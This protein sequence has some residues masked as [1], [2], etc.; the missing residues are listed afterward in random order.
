MPQWLLLLWA[1]LLSAGSAH[2]FLSQGDYERLTEYRSDYDYFP[3]KHWAKAGRPELLGWSSKK[4]AAAKSY[5]DTLATAAVVIVDNGVIVDAW[6]QPAARYKCHSVRKSLL[7]ALY[8]IRV[9]TGDISLSSS[10]AELK[11]DDAN[12]PLTDAEK[13]ARVGDLLKAR[14]GVYH[15]AAYETSGMRS[16]R[17]ERGSHAPG[18]HFFY[19][20][21]DFNA[22]LTI[23]ERQT[24]TGMFEEFNSRIAQPLQME[25]FR[26]SDTTYYFERA[27]SQ[28]PA[29]LFRMSALDLARFGLLYLRNG[30]WQ[31]KPIVPASWIKAS[32]TDYSSRGPRGLGDYLSGYGYLWWVGKDGYAA[33]G[34]GEQLLMVMPK[35]RL[36]IVHRVDT[37]QRGAQVSGAQLA[38]LLELILSA[39]PSR[40]GAR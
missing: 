33:V 36:V 32:A 29:Y 37:D 12:P 2:A 15:P 16:K 27:K 26:L 22:L 24:K 3:K 11:I 25:Q 6:G 28:H 1:L 39:R 20:N 30:V 10:L 14:S 19:N 38:R 13:Q 5:A 18:T 31:G 4:L 23:F 40:E 34:A 35:Y 21:W 8:G 9:E 7:S 17:P